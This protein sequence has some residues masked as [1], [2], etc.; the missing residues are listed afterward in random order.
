MKKIAIVI[1]IIG[2]IYASSWC[3]TYRKASL[4][5][6]NAM[7]FEENGEYIFAIKGK[8]NVEKYMGG[9]QIVID[10][11]D[12]TI[13]KPSIYKKSKKRIEKIITEKIDENIGNEIFEKYF[14][15]DNKYLED[16][17]IRVYSLIK[18]RDR[19]EA[20]KYYLEILEAF[21]MSEKIEEIR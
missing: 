8:K 15:K 9:Y 3:S 19:D 11:F 1:G 17:V 2:I 18:E 16:I 6:E 5:Y 10:M 13:F 20:E 7:K 21:P 14:G 4:Y 12:E